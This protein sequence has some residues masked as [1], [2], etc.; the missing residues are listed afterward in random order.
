M[1]NKAILCVDDEQD[2]LERL[3][4]LL[5]KHFGDTYEI[6]KA[7]NADD[8]FEIIEELIEDELKLIVILSDWL[9]PGM[10]GDD[11]LVKVHI[12]HPEVV[13]IMLAGQVDEEAMK[14]ARENADLFAHHCKPWDE[15]E[16]INTIQKS[17]H[18]NT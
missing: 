10:K 9:M 8:A 3:Y 11:F 15:K 2:Q 16:L 13:K 12:D 14:N 17:L 6:E 5:T 1:K 18:R 4:N 7:E